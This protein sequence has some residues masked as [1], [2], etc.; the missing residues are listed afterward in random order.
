MEAAWEAR[1]KRTGPTKKTMRQKDLRARQLSMVAAEGCPTPPTTPMDREE[2]SK[3]ISSPRS[4]R[5]RIS[6][7][8]KG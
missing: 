6:E 2:D 4:S 3:S 1:T 7:V 8:S 5:R